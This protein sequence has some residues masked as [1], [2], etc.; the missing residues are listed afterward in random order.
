MNEND[1]LLNQYGLHMSLKELAVVFKK[2]E[3][4]IR[5]KISCEKFPVETFLLDGTRVAKTEDVAT[6]LKSI[7]P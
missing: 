1:Y 2:T 4:A 5:N 3:K 6:Y 7:A